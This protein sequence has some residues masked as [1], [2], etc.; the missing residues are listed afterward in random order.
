MIAQLEN[1][2][3]NV[4]SL[5][6]FY[7]SLP[8]PVMRV[9]LN[10]RAY[11]LVRM[12]YAKETFL[13]LD[14]LLER[15]EF[16][17]EQL[18]DFVEE[19]I[20]KITEI[21]KSIPYYQNYLNNDQTLKTLPVLTRESVRKNYE[22]LLNRQRKSLVRVFTSGS[23]GSGV[24][25]YYD[26]EAYLLNW[27]YLMKQRIWAKVDPRELRITF[28]G[29]RI[30]TP[31]RDKPPFWIKNHLENQYLMSI[32]HFSEKYAPH[33]IRFLEKKQGLVLEGFA[34]VLYLVAQYVKELKGQL[35]FKA[36]FSTGEPM[37]PFMRKEVEEAFGAKVYDSYGMTEWAGLILECEKGGYHVLTDYGRL[38]ILDEENVSVPVNE[39]GYMTW[40]GFTNAAMPFIRY[41][42]GDKGIWKRGACS[43]GKPYPLV[44]P[45]I[46]RVSDFV[47]T[48][49][50]KVLSPRAINQV[51]KDKVTF[52]ACQFIQNSQSEL[53]VRVVPD[54]A[55]DYRA[56]LDELKRSVAAIVG[57]DVIVEEE[58]ADQPIRRGTQG[59][60]P[61]IISKVNYENLNRERVC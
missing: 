4:K 35:Q 59:K 40:T 49:S 25:V 58:I 23:S 32:F 27:A 18:D 28:Y 53:I 48:P 50:G 8:V 45:T 39:E 24:P 22:H 26:R 31:A 5:R 1:M 46:T 33:Y 37:Y 29:A 38:E 54:K 15:D 14:K 19:Q 6:R 10:L 17:S 61:F 30:I 12:R 60:I 44:Q 43:C 9:L 21:A 36:I 34:S 52:K 56:E 42:I 41:K 57:D 3:R 16:T 7:Y 55:A 11:P 2:M 20:S 13:W 51:L 47:I